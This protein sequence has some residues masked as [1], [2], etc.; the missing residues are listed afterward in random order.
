[1]MLSHLQRMPLRNSR[2]GS[3]PRRHRPHGCLPHLHCSR[4]RVRQRESPRHWRDTRGHFGHRKSFYFKSL[5]ISRDTTPM[6]V[7]SNSLIVQRKRTESYSGRGACPE[8]HREWVCPS[9]LLKITG[10]SF[11]SPSLLASRF[12]P[13]CLSIRPPGKLRV[14]CP[15][16]RVTEQLLP[17]Y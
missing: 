16:G 9:G 10:R 2:L 12:S 13:P 4:M 5:P 17:E 14:H 3:E 7:S 1:M 6:P 8:S 15:F 11:P